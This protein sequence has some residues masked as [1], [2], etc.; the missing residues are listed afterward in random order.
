VKSQRPFSFLAV[1]ERSTDHL[2]FKQMN[3]C[4]R[5]TDGA[6]ETVLGERCK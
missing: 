2:G 1:S 6:R 3:G 5:L 4:T